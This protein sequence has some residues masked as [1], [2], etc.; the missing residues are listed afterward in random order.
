MNKK[1][2]IIS[3]VAGGLLMSG[4]GQAKPSRPNPSSSISVVFK[5]DTSSA[6]CFSG[7]SQKAP[8][9]IQPNQE[10]TV[11]YNLSQALKFSYTDCKQN[12]ISFQLNKSPNT[13]YCKSLSN[14]NGKTV[15]AGIILKNFNNYK[16]QVLEVSLSKVGNNYEALCTLGAYRPSN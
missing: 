3:V 12:G 1:I 13:Q 16:L 4:V 6:V 15:I 7:G 11:N 14:V 5:N 2:L 9:R 10:R 8:Y